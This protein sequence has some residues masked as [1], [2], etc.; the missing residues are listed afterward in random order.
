MTGIAYNFVCI[1]FIETRISHLKNSCNL[2]SAYL[3]TALFHYSSSKLNNF[4]F[5][6][7]EIKSV[8]A[9]FFHSVDSLA[10]LLLNVKHCDWTNFIRIAFNFALSH[11]F[12][13]QRLENYW[14]ILFFLNCKPAVK[15]E[16]FFDKIFISRWSIFIHSPAKFTLIGI[17][18]KS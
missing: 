12:W 17:A 11:S 6:Y 15:S 1:G 14:K 16:E 3:H 13:S 10:S 7:D 8:N 2:E 18:M 9:A 5:I 4:F